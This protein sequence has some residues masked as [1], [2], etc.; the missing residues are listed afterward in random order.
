MIVFHENSVANNIESESL[1]IYPGQIIKYLTHGEFM[2][3]EGIKTYKFIKHFKQ[4]QS[5]KDELVRKRAL[6]YLKDLLSTEGGLLTKFLQYKGTSAEEL[7][8][9]SELSSSKIEGIEYSEIMKVLS[10]ELGTRA[11][12]FKL[13]SEDAIAASVG[14]VHFATLGADKVALKIQYPNI[15]QVFIEQ[16]KLLK[17][18][19]SI[20]NL[21]P[22]KK[23]GVDISVYQKE[24]SRLV[25]QECDYSYEARELE[26]WRGYL[27][28]HSNCHVPK[29]YPEYST[30]S[31]IVESFIDGQSIDDI[32]KE[33][34]SPE[35][36]AV[37][38]TLIS[39]YFDLFL[40]H[41]VI[42]GD[43]NHGNF[44]FKRSD[45][46][47]YFID[48]GQTIRFS[49]RF[50]SAFLYILDAKLNSKPY[51]A[52]SFFIAIGFD[53]DKIK[54][55][56]NKLD[57]ILDILVQPLVCEY[58]IDLKDWRYREELDLLLGDEKWWFRSAG[59]T[60]FFSFMKS[61]LGL[62]N[63]FSKLNINTFFRKILVEQIDQFSADVKVIELFEISEFCFETKPSTKL[64]IHVQ[65]GDV[66]KVK[67]T[68]PFM[69]I[70]DLGRYLDATI[71]QKIE[72]QGVDFEE[73][74][75]SALDDGARLLPG[76]SKT[77]FTY[78][79]DLKTITIQLT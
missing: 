11:Q 76:Q 67:L 29:L 59:G 53:E 2:L 27:L 77:I 44:I 79:E 55:I 46:S 13:I 71:I 22:M 73:I 52:F 54:L 43:T 1:T 19:P 14:Q 57:L 5:S 61:F 34:S 8:E 51:C 38:K 75:R 33:W 72:G 4:Y 18:L 31:V 9:L 10:Q 3:S 21:G 63:L 60:E 68:L 40:K 37:S 65:E 78:E 58:A 56:A 35:K 42:Q 69:S 32:K 50:V 20:M 23:W 6:L 64:L 30:S 62:K 47:V 25:E 74:I 41:R 39:A 26:L 16:L 66:D 12:D 36:L 15:K 24:L 70:F 48:L 17:V 49:Q 7:E 28:E 45:L